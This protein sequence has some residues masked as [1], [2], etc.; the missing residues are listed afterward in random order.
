[1]RFFMA[2]LL[3]YIRRLSDEELKRIHQY[4]ASRFEPGPHILHISMSGGCAAGLGDEAKRLTQAVGAKVAA[5]NL[6]LI[7]MRDYLCQADPDIK[8]AYE[9]ASRF[10]A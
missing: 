2:C 9:W 8:Q 3:F 4:E 5:R 10:E 1:M 7:V 6:I